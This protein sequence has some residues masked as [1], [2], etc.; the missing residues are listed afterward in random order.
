MTAPH[1]REL[2]TLIP[3]IIQ[4]LI[5][6]KNILVHCR[7]GLGRAGTVCACCLLHF[8]FTAAQAITIIRKRRPG[9]IQ[10]IAQEQIVEK[11]ERTIKI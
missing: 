2:Q 3:L 10:T 4:Q 1:L 7:A 8:G 5:T 11:Y 9:A 6:G